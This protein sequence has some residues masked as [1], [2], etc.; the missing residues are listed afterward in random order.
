MPTN[1]NFPPASPDDSGSQLDAAAAEKQ[2]KDQEEWLIGN[3]D[4]VKSAIDAVDNAATSDDQAVKDAAWADVDAVNDAL[5]M[6][7]KRS[8]ALPEDASD[9]LKAMFGENTSLKRLCVESERYDEMND[10]EKMAFDVIVKAYRGVQDGLSEALSQDS[11]FAPVD[12]GSG[13]ESANNDS[14]PDK[15][16]TTPE[17]SKENWN[18]VRKRRAELQ[19]R[20]EEIDAKDEGSL[21]DDEKKERSE[22]ERQINNFNILI[23][24]EPSNAQE[25]EFSRQIS[26][27]REELKHLKDRK[28][29]SE[30]NVVNL[31]ALLERDNDDQSADSLRAAVA[32]NE[33]DIA[34]T[35]KSIELVEIRLSSLEGLRE[36]AKNGAV[37]NRAEEISQPETP[38]QAGERLSAQYE[39]A[40]SK[41]SQLDADAA[42]KT[43][44]D[45]RLRAVWRTVRK[46]DKR[47]SRDIRKE[48]YVQT[49]KALADAAR[50]LAVWKAQDKRDKGLYEGDSDEIK[51]KM[52]DDVFDD[53]RK[54]LDND[55]REKTT[56]VLQERKE[57]RKGFDKF[58]AGIGKM[59]N[60]GGKWKRILK[61]GVP[62]FVAGL[63]ATLSGVGWP[64]TAVV[65]VGLGAGIGRGSRLAALDSKLEARKDKD[66]NVSGLVSDQAYKLFRTRAKKEAETHRNGTAT[67]IARFSELILKNGRIGSY[68]EAD[69]A[70]GEADKNKIVFGI[71]VAAGV[72]VG[73]GINNL[74][75]HRAGAVGDGGSGH[76]DT[77]VDSGHSG[78]NDGTPHHYD[79]QPDEGFSS[80][81]EGITNTNTPD[82]TAINP[83][84]GIEPPSYNGEQYPWEWAKN[85]FGIDGATPMLHRLAETAAANGYD[86]VWH[87]SGTSQWL[88][89]NGRSD[90][91]YVVG[92]LRQF[93]FELAA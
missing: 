90:T 34:E 47:S 4:I 39:D 68:K 10:D 12:D 31:R 40:L 79:A 17:E 50:E 84:L 62:G 65:S 7:D 32:I 6:I 1:Q 78:T 89:I 51:Q 69:E 29:I 70:K 8:S 76:G 23:D 44:G 37:D 77:G 54:M 27:E 18:E 9:K 42:T 45:S 13:E 88:S 43:R 93:A 87:G 86:V 5:D 59:L 80:A 74:Q 35:D 22:L 85:A 83:D 52:S 21:T 11:A 71:G 38:E 81:K 25:Q 53:M 19:A 82:G 48:E 55:V 24:G 67:E 66:G 36:R 63:G 28:V 49:G 26:V 16:S 33:E 73:F 75:A 56:Q 30:Q 20:I 3:D 64:I 46:K 72:L 92:V 60:G 58:L 61:N 15:G 14:N 57:N 2:I 91:A 41:Y